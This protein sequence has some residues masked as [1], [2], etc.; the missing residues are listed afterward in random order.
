ML[1]VDDDDDE[2]RPPPLVW[3]LPTEP[4]ALMRALAG[5]GRDEPAPDPAAGEVGPLLARFAEWPIAAVMPDQAEAGAV[6]AGL[7]TRTCAAAWPSAGW[8][9]R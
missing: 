2:W 3:T 8:A 5:L 7:L 1:Y 6:R 9:S 4:R